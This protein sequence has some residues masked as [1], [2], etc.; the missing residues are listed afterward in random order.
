MIEEVASMKNG[1]CDFDN[2]HLTTLITV[3]QDNGIKI[4]ALCHNIETLT[5][6]H[7]DMIRWLLLV[8]CVIALGSKAME[9]VDSL[10]GKRSSV[11][12]Y[13]SKP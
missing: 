6:Q 7:R 2:D 5:V 4:D 9:M 8:V 11:G 10:W 12:V 3:T 13:A 1:T